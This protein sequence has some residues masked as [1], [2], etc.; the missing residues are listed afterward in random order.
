MVTPAVELVQSAEH[1]CQAVG[2]RPG[3]DPSQQ[4]GAKA[5]FGKHHRP[6]FDTN[7]SAVTGQVAPG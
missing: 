6:A 3:T 4:V 1:V 7:P 5:L 2:S